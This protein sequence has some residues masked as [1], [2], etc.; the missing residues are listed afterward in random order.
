[1]FASAEHL[2]NHHPSHNTAA[3]DVSLPTNF[4]FPTLFGAVHAVLVSDHG[5]IIRHPCTPEE[6]QQPTNTSPALTK[7]KITQLIIRSLQSGTE[8]L[9]ILMAALRSIGSLL[10]KVNARRIIIPLGS[11]TVPVASP[12]SGAASILATSSHVHFDASGS[13]E[14]SLYQRIESS[15]SVGGFQRPVFG[16]R[17]RF[18]SLVSHPPRHAPALFRCYAV[19]QPYPEDLEMDEG[20]DDEVGTE[21]V[22]EGCRVQHGELW[23]EDVKIH[24]VECGDKNGELVIGQF[25]LHFGCHSFLN[26]LFRSDSVCFC[27]FSELDR[28]SL[29]VNIS[30]LQVV[31]V[32]GFPNFWYVWKNQFQALAGAG[33]HVVAPDLRGYNSSSKPKG[34]Q[35]YSRRLVVSDIVRVIDQLGNGKPAT[36]V[37]H[38]WGGFVTWAVAE[39]FPDKVKKAVIV[40]VAHTSVFAEALRSNLRQLRQSWYIGFFQL[41]WLPEWLMTHSNFKSLKAAFSGTTFQPIDIDRHVK[42]YGKAGAAEG[43]I[44]YYRAAMRGHW[45]PAPSAPRPIRVELPVDL[46]WGELDR[47]LRKELA[48]IPKAIAPNAVVKLLP[49][50]SHWPMWDDPKLFNA[51]LLESLSSQRAI[52]GDRVQSAA[53]TSNEGMAD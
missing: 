12:A 30:C 24:Y 5:H 15:E 34:I 45:A 52:S 41:P 26:E 49:H 27:Y 18:S 14:F 13:S 10:P 39:D 29:F 50:C 8:R 20:Q 17:S 11:Q 9:R 4:V 1:M 46:I 37:G 35:N 32:H 53:I 6:L 25:C 28:S 23:N 51:L 38:D 19:A 31:L 42:A 43:G 21:E 33:Y 22:I 16:R 44:N 40:N 36:V 3:A 47:Y 7:L 2:W 48:V